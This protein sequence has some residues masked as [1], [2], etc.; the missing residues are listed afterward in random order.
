MKIGS[1]D[2]TTSFLQVFQRFVV[3]ITE[4]LLFIQNFFL[5]ALYKFYYYFIIF[6]F[7][8]SVFLL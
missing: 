5:L 8:N 2:N 4:K 7:C 6:F 3:E 1:G